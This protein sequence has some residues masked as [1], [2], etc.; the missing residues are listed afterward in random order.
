MPLVVGILTFMSSKFSCCME[1]FIT[2]G[3][4]RAML[5]GNFPCRGFPQAGTKL[6]QGSTV[7]ALGAGRGF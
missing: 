2:S 3:P 1:I 6:G 4:G 5:L 7:L